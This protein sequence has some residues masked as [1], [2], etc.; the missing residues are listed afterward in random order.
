MLR[1]RPHGAAWPLLRRKQP[2]S[3]LRVQPL[4]ATSAWMRP[5]MHAA[6]MALRLDPPPDTNTASLA[7]G[8]GVCAAAEPCAGGAWAAAATCT[9]R[10][11]PRRPSGAG[12][13]SQ[14][15]AAAAAGTGGAAARAAELR[16]L[17][18][19][20]LFASDGAQCALCPPL[21]QAG[22]C[23]GPS[24]AAAGR[25]LRQRASPGDLGTLGAKPA[26]VQCSVSNLKLLSM[27]Q[28]SLVPFRAVAGCRRK[29]LSAVHPRARLSAPHS[30]CETHCSAHTLPSAASCSPARARRG[31]LSA[32]G[33]RAVAAAAMGRQGRLTLDLMDQLAFYGA[34]HTHPINQG[35][36][37]RRWRPAAGRQAGSWRARPRRALRCHAA[38]GST[39]HP[40]HSRPQP[41][42]LCLCLPS[43]GPPWCGS[44][45][46]AVRVPSL[47]PRRRW[48][49]FSPSCRP[50]SRGVCVRVCE[51]VCIC[52]SEP[53]CA[54]VRARKSARARGHAHAGAR[55]RRALTAAANPLPMLPT[56][57]RA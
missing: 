19:P 13:G 6:W 16:A 52:A 43:C 34:Y 10:R 9:L 17:H 51:C 40:S 20:R 12:C 37:R 24:I 57:S 55:R 31:P 39:H 28:S 5:S 11:R 50:G 41:S 8:G 46:R 22:S 1:C 33:R 26:A 15:F 44:R 14:R 4:T 2:L 18:P 54:S 21:L 7:R 49:R 32:P 25:E 36:R 29:P 38:C 53:V 48:R 45:P 27:P 3:S 35:A 30:V 42:T 23:R 47:Q 56:T